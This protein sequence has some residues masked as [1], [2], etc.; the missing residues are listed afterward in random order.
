MSCWLVW[1]VAAAAATDEV[2]GAEVKSECEREREKV[3][4]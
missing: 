3:S 2:A 1:S 4:E